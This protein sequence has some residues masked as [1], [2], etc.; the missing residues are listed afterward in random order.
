MNIAPA[1]CEVC[2][3][4]ICPAR[5]LTLLERCLLVAD[6]VAEEVASVGPCYLIR[7]HA[8]MR[9]SSKMRPARPSSLLLLRDGGLGV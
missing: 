6:I 8:T 4:G 9:L 1:P 5:W 7:G 2:T 3:M